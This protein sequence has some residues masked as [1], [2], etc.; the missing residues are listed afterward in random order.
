VVAVGGFAAVETALGLK[1]INGSSILWS[2]RRANSLSA[3][4]PKRSSSSL[5]IR[6]LMLFI[7][8]VPLPKLYSQV[9]RRALRCLQAQSL[10]WHD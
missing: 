3:A 7:V 4:V 6:L 1:W 2:K 10:Y 9:P 8:A 5:R